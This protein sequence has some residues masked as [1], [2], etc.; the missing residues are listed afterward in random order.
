MGVI[1][2]V[3]IHDPNRGKLDPRAHNFI[4]LGFSPTQKGYNFSDPKTR[5][6]FVSV[7]VT[8]FEKQP[9]FDKT[10]LQG[11]SDDEARFWE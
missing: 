2:F 1:A 10:L 11:K 3:H 4:F 5:I 9:Y 6:L 8:F 7:G